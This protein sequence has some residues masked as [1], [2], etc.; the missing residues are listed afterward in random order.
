[1]IQE[2]EL[3]GPVEFH[4][5]AFKYL[6]KKGYTDFRCRDYYRIVRGKAAAYFELSGRKQVA[7][8]K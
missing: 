1:M 4:G 6:D 7:G 8:V 5:E 2:L 3:S